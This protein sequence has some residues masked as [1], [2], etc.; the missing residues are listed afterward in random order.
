MARFVIILIFTT[1]LVGCAT[2][3]DVE[4]A[5]QSE[6]IWSAKFS[7]PNPE[8]TRIEQTIT[9]TLTDVDGNK[10]ALTEHR[11]WLF[12]ELRDDA[13]I[14]YHATSVVNGWWDVYNGDLYLHYELSTLKVNI[15]S[16]RVSAR[17]DVSPEIAIGINKYRDTY[18]QRVVDEMRDYLRDA[19]IEDYK[20]YDIQGATYFNLAIQNDSLYYTATDLGRVGFKK[21]AK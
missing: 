13:K 15:D 20:R 6:G 11:R 4:K 18:L 14:T 3:N 2:S 17:D 19:M 9:Y 8:G 16:F 12:D 7:F 10:G 1:I 21:I 5:K